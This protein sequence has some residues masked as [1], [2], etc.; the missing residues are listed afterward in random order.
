MALIVRPSIEEIR[1]AIGLSALPRLSEATKKR[2]KEGAAPGTDSYEEL[3][4]WLESDPV[5]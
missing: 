3:K 2:Q 4:V 5:R 1:L